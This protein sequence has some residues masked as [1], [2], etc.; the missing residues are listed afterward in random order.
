MQPTPQSLLPL[1]LP[2]HQLLLSLMQLTPQPLP[3]LIVL[4]L[5][6]LQL[7]PPA[8]PLLWQTAV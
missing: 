7:S 8:L 4:L 3:P 1:T 6:P 2:T 5:P